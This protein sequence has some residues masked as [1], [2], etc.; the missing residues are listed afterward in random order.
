MEVEFSFSRPEKQYETFVVNINN[1]KK[2]VEK[3]YRL[4][5]YFEVS[6]AP[7]FW[8]SWRQ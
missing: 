1:N 2:K 6:L 8:I 3:V 4:F 5:D 7:P